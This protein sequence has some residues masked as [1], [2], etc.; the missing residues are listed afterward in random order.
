MSGTVRIDPDRVD[1]RIRM[2]M[3]H[4]QNPT[5]RPKRRAKMREELEVLIKIQDLYN[6]EIAAR[7]AQAK[8]KKLEEVAPELKPTAVEAE[9]AHEKAEAMLTTPFSVVPPKQEEKKEQ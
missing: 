5:L 1:C 3:K 7:I 6:R 9:V 4:I 2:L 8:Q